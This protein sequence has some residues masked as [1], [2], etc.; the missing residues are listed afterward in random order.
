PLYCRMVGRTNLVGK[1]YREA[2]PELVGTALPDVLDH[3]YRTGEP[4]S[5]GEMLVPLDTNGDGGVEECFFTFNLEALRDASGNVYGMMAVAQEITDQARARRSIEVAQADREALLVKLETANRA[6]DEF[7]AMLGHELRNPL[8]PIVTA[9]HLMKRHGQA[10]REQ[11][12]IER[13]VRHLVRLVDDLLDVSRLTRGKI[14]LKKELVEISDV[15]ANAVEMASDLFEDRRH[16]LSIDV[17]KEG[18]R[19]E[20][21]PVRLA[22]VAANLLTNAARYTEPGGV[23][24]VHAE[25]VGEEIVIVVKDNGVGISPELLPRVFDLF[26]QGQQKTDRKEGGLG[27]GLTLVKS[28]VS[29]Q[30]GVVEA[31]SPGPGKGSEFEIRLPTSSKTNVEPHTPPPTSTT[32][33][34]VKSKRILV[35]D[36]NVDSAEM[37]SMML[38]SV[39]YEV[40]MAHDGPEA[41]AAIENFT[42]DVALLDIGLPVMTGYELGERLHATPQGKNCRL[43]AL[44]G[45]GQSHDRAQSKASGFE[46]HLVKPVDMRALLQLIATDITPP[47]S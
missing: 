44:T 38:E 23:I 8:A 36:D 20:G 4:Y 40:A 37:M 27:L 31:R 9:L 33:K 30:G 2:F 21:D 19:L 45:Y 28:L 43:I 46:A 5:S 3:V 42:P 34:P 25:R 11:E 41:L 16:Q 35:V 26:V 47:S 17:P 12:I 7:L 22:Q 1:T 6:K 32:T 10:N 13:Q 24:S 18:L 39:G 29:M 15:L 14:T